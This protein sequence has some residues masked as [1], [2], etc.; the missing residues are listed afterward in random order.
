MIGV[1]TIVKDSYD[2]LKIVGMDTDFE[3]AFKSF[4]KF[5]EG[6]NNYHESCDLREHTPDPKY[7]PECFE[8]PDNSKLLKDYREQRE[9]SYL[10]LLLFSS[11][12]IGGHR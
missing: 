1:Y 12:M 7:M 6:Y 3:T 2:G 11:E 10:R 9:D 5:V 4:M 8:M